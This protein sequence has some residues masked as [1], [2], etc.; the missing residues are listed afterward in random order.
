[1]H[2]FL[3]NPIIRSQKIHYFIPV[4]AKQNTPTDN[5]VAERFIR[6]FKNHKIYD[7]TIQSKLSNSI[8]IEPNFKPYRTI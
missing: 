1:M 2:N 5:T 8:M 3:A 6:T 7:I 4:I